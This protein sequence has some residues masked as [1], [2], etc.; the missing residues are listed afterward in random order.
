MDQPLDAQAQDAE[1]AGVLQ[2][3]QLLDGKYKVVGELGRGAMGVVYRG[4]HAALDRPVAIKTLRHEFSNDSDLASRFEREARAASA[5]GHPHIIDV[6][7]LGRTPEGLLFMV[8]ELLDGKSL[9]QLLEERR[10]LPVPMAVDIISQVLGGLSAAHKNGIVHRDLKPDNIFVVDNEDHPNF[11]KIVD[12]GIAKQLTSRG[13]VNPK[14]STGT[15]VGTVMGTPLYMAP[16]QAIGRVEAI[17]N[18]TDLYAAGV[19]LYEMLCGRTPY[20]G[21]DFAVVMGALL[22]GKYPLPRALRPDVP[23]HVEA[24]IVRALDRDMARRFPSAA[25]MREALA[26]E[27]TGERTPAPFSERTPAPLASGGIGDAPLTLATLDGQDAGPPGISL[28]AD[29]APVQPGRPRDP[30]ADR[31]APPP[32][33]EASLELGGTRWGSAPPPRTM[34][35]PGKPATHARPDVHPDGRSPSPPSET[36]PQLA[37][38]P[39]PAP[40]KGTVEPER[41]VSRRTRRLLIK[42]GVVVGVLLTARVTYFFLKDYRSTAAVPGHTSRGAVLVTV[43]VDPTNATVQVDHIPTTKRDLSLEAGVSHNLNAT[44]P[45]RIT[46]RFSFDAKPALK[47]NVHLGRALSQPTPGAP[48][49]SPDEMNVTY[50]DSSRTA[51]EIDA[52]FTKLDSF[53]QCLALVA[54]D[55]APARSARRLRSEDLALC[56]TRVREARAMVPTMTALETAADGFI[57]AAQS[58][59]KLDQVARLQVEFRAQAAAARAQWQQEELA[60]EEKQGRKAGWYMRRLTLAAL[61]WQRALDASPAVPDTVEER[62]AALDQAHREFLDYAQSQRQELARTG[63]ANDFIK[64]AEDTVTLAHKP[65]NGITVLSACRRLVSAFNALA[66]E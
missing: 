43:E 9:G 11:V 64:A 14:A 34:D 3:G 27:R 40:P 16:E 36:V 12:F 5:I 28:L 48:P 24:A 33:H 10:Q 45:G 52:A 56:Q 57:A 63:G 15:L 17:D 4:V 41:I 22:E 25:A 54:G 1:I 62:V 20:Q 18:R 8:M 46:R 60:L 44:A 13:R 39:R 50:P 19:V 55:D 61:S 23:A 30:S 58:G 47:L 53:F 66:L 21:D 26:S 2:P 51:K 31:F 42:V 32:S 6:F 37:Y 7:D 35:G 29:A 59:Q 49:P 38:R 65:R